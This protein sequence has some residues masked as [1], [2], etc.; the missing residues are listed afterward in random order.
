[1][2]GTFL[3]LSSVSAKAFLSTLAR[4]ERALLWELLI[5]EGSAISI[6]QDLFHFFRATEPKELLERIHCEQKLL[7]KIDY[8][9]C[10]KRIVRQRIQ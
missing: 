1:M 5:H 3:E 7:D 9:I 6:D 8:I 2:T 4:S 10:E